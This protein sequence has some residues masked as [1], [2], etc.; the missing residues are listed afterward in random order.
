MTSHYTIT[1]KQKPAIYHHSTQSVKFSDGSSCSYNEGHCNIYESTI[2]TWLIE[3]PRSSCGT[4]I[5]TVLYEGLANITKS[6]TSPSVLVVETDK[7]RFAMALKSEAIMVGH[8][9]YKTEDDSIIVLTGSPSTL[10]N[11]EAPESIDLNAFHNMDLKLVYLERNIM[12]RTN[13]YINY[14]YRGTVIYLEIIC[15]R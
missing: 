9:G 1:V 5:Y 7:Q 8:D 2:A 12:N 15:I 4:N 10:P 6:S 13:D 14:S 11:H 3:S